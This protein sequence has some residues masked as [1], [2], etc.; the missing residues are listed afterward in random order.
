[1]KPVLKWAGGKFRLVPDI[2]RF[3][4]KD[5][6][7]LIEPFVGAGALFFGLTGKAVINDANCELI[8]FYLQVR[9]RPEA[10]LKMANTWAKDE[11]A[12]YEV[13]DLDREPLWHMTHPVVRAGRF[14]YLNKM[15]FNG[16]WRVS[17]KNYHNVPWNKKPE[18]NM[19]QLDHLLAASK[20]LKDAVI[21]CDDY[22]VACEGAGPGDFVY[23]D[24]P[25]HTSTF[26]SYAKGGWGKE[27]WE[28]LV[29]TAL[30]INLNG[31]TVCISNLGDPE[32]TDPFKGTAFHVVPVVHTHIFAA[33]TEH[34]KK[35]NEVLIVNVNARN[36]PD[37]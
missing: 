34:R 2:V 8:N 17:R 37:A 23:F 22:T 20:R 33:K 10:V 29:N 36:T 12:Y 32:I 30:T 27:E 19:P 25:Y 5:T 13:R 4:P 26:A 7:R 21:T 6:K 14:L 11:D 35:A 16:M 15:A 3:L 18:T 24:P 28:D 1:M 9:D 31:A